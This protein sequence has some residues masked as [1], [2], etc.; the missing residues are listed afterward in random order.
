ME[1]SR[2]HGDLNNE[3]GQ[4][5]SQCIGEHQLAQRDGPMG[6]RIH[7][8]CAKY[9]LCIPSI[10][11]DTHTGDRHTHFSHLHGLRRIDYILLP[12]MWLPAVTCFFVDRTLDLMAAADDHFLAVVKFAGRFTVKQSS[13]ARRQKITAQGIRKCTLESISLFEEAICNI[14]VPAWQTDLHTHKH[15]LT[16]Q[17]HEAAELLECRK[18]QQRKVYASP[19]VVETSQTRY[20][21][22]HRA[23][24][25]RKLLRRVRL[26]RFF[27]AWVARPPDL[28]IEH[29][30]PADEWYLKCELAL[31]G[32]ELRRTAIQQADNLVKSKKAFLLDTYAQVGVD[33]G[34]YGAMLPGCAGELAA[35]MVGS[36]VGPLRFCLITTVM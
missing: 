33:R 34:N 2:A 6:Q 20:W 5:G 24:H 22:L 32:I 10:F 3:L 36:S 15:D 8:F 26:F 4:Y 17:V 16:E 7:D 13:V 18:I 1:A 11:A 29:V 31:Y 14:S 23:D 12:A 27:A 19:E 28:C 9:S 25:H 21:L 35:R 30:A